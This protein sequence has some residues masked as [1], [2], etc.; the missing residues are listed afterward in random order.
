MHI[1]IH[2]VKFEVHGACNWHKNADRLKP[3]YG[4]KGFIKI[5]SFHLSVS[6][7]HQL[8]LIPNNLSIFIGLVLEDPFGANNMN[9]FKAKNKFSYIISYKL[10]KLFMHWL[11]LVFILKSFFYHFRLKLGKVAM[12]CYMIGQKYVSLS[13]TKTFI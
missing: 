6:L 7:S 5:Y 3:S 10:I 1:H 9:I 4:S 8:R 2:L 11:N 12:V 13:K